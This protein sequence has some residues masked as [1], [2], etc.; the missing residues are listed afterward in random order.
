MT[1]NYKVSVN[2]AEA[3]EISSEEV[4]KLDAI[5]IAASKFHILQDNIS[6]KAEITEANF[7]NKTYQVKVNNNTYNVAIFNELDSLI[8][9]MGFEIGTAKKVNEIKAPMPGLILEINVK[10]GQEVK[11]DDALLILEAMKM[12]N[13]LSSPRDGIIKSISVSKNDTVDKGELLIEFE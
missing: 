12:E 8:K 3:L 4:S 10:V 13:V 7:N 2:N 6:Y 11:E 1:N 9:E 5:K